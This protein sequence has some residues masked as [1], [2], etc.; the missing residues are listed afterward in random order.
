MS[1]SEPSSSGPSSPDPS[2]AGPPPEEGAPAG[3]AERLPESARAEYVA[4]L[5]ALAAQ[6]SG[7]ADSLARRRWVA[8]G[9]VDGL[10][11]QLLALHAQNIGATETLLARFRESL[12]VVGLVTPTEGSPAARLPQPEEEEEREAT[13]AVRA[14]RRESLEDKVQALEAQLT[15]LRQMEQGLVGDVLGIA[16]GWGAADPSEA[17]ARIPDG[18]LEAVRGL[19]A[20]AWGGEAE[21]DPPASDGQLD[22]VMAWCLLRGDQLICHQR[23]QAGDAEVAK[24][25][26]APVSGLAYPE[27]AVALLRQLASDREA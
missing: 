17:L 16:R 5:D 6:A 4:A 7:T 26:Q 1:P 13:D 25:M 12:E 15:R 19:A 22:R 24:R 14:A 27:E 8:A 10:S 3:L 2:P 11:A 20:A 21:E 18:L 9:V 23:L